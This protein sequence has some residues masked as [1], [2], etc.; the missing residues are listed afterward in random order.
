MT[1]AEFPV[2]ALD[3]E[4][5]GKNPFE[6][7]VVEAAAV[8]VHPDRTAET[9]W[10]SI[11]DPGVEIPDEAAQIHG[12]TTQ[13]AKAEGIPTEVA[14]LQLGREIW[15]HIET[16]GG[17][18]ALAIFNGR[19]DWP[20]LLAEAERHGVEFPCFAPILDPYLLDRMLDRQRRGKR[21]L[22]LV[23]Q[24]YRVE[25]GDKAHGATADATAAGQVLWHLVARFPELATQ[26]LA[27]LF[28][29]QVLGAEQDRQGFQDWMRRN[30]DQEFTSVPGWP[31]PVE[32]ERRS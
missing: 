32:P 2:L 30:V 22:S 31:V 6:A 4:T 14:L 18:A 10:S 20:L 27:S 1:W 5:T 25:L 16:Y 11:V 21:T 19:Y 17:Q 13:R 15:R 8:L 12:I 24:H 9:V 23:A 26:P 29:R 7:R 3:T 28:L